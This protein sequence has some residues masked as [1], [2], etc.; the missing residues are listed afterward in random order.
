MTRLARIVFLALVAATF[1][2][3]FVAQRLK[4]ATPVVGV[5]GALFF[6]PNG[7]GRKDVTNLVL[8]MKQSDVVTVDMIDVAG[9][10]VRRLATERRVNP[11]TVLRLRWDG[12]TD[13]GARAPDGLYRVRASL[14]APLREVRL[15]DC[16]IRKFFLCHFV[17]PVAKRALGVLHDVALVHE[18][19]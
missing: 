3:F 10:P 19:H 5:R 11:S 14:T 1:G 8:R 7:D 2:A 13:S 9:E 4:G 18:S 15:S 6:S 17:A 12:R 16:R